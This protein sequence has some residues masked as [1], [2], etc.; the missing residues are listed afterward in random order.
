MC[1]LLFVDIVAYWHFRENCCMLIFLSVKLYIDFSL[2]KIDFVYETCCILIFADRTYRM[3]IFYLWNLLHVDFTPRVTCALIFLL[4]KRIWLFT[5]VACLFLLMKL[6]ACGFFCSWSD[7]SV[8][9]PCETDFVH[10]TLCTLI[11]IPRTFRMLILVLE[12][13]HIFVFHFMKITLIFLLVILIFI[14]VIFGVLIFVSGT[15]C[16]LICVS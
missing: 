7:I 16:M 8:F 2:Q 6:V 3:L 10:G 12:I 4:V 13:Y 11:F 9:P 15:C 1:F 5:L 14:M